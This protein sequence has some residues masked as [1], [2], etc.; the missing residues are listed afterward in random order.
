MDKGAPL[1]KVDTR[2]AGGVGGAVNAA[3]PPLSPV[4]ASLIAGEEGPGEAFRIIAVHRSKGL[5]ARLP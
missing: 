3:Q 2:G 5:W 1:H 4:Y